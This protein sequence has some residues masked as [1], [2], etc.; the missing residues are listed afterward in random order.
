[1][2]KLN[3]TFKLYFTSIHFS[4][5]NFNHFNMPLSLTSLEEKGDETFY[6]IVDH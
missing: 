3:I 2:T 5:F 1:M 4:H 6:I